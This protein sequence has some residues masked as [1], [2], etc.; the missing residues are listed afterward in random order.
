V[1]DVCQQTLHMTGCEDHAMATSFR[2]SCLFAAAFFAGAVCTMAGLAW[3]T[4]E[5]TA[6]VSSPHAY[7]V[8]LDE[9]K[10]NFVFA[11]SLA[12]TYHRTVRMSDGSSR[13]ISL[14]AISKNGVPMVEL[15]DESSAGTHHSIMGRNGTT[16]DGGL[17]ISIKDMPEAQQDMRQSIGPVRAQ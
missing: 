6:F 2:Q 5:S 15:W 9:I 14:R 13:K 4:T 16:S 12:D 3:S 10:Q 17:M 8:S 11:D 7:S 1:R